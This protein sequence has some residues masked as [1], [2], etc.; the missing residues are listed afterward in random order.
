MNSENYSAISPQTVRRYAAPFW[1]F[2]PLDGMAK[3]PLLRFASMF[4]AGDQQE[5]HEE[6]LLARRRLFTKVL[7]SIRFFA[8]AIPLDLLRLFETLH[9]LLFRGEVAPLA[10]F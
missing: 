7:E 6:D 3:A 5:T 9:R 10:P 4:P 8:R 2:S 1:N